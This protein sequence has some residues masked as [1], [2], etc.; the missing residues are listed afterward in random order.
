ML[1]E[2]IQLLSEELIL[3][4]QA[5]ETEQSKRKFILSANGQKLREL[6]EKSD[7]TSAR[8]PVASTIE[9]DSR[10]PPTALNVYLMACFASRFFRL[11]D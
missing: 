6:T 3:F 2:F 10:A 8:K 7:S 5:L 1:Q 4:R 9:V 11:A